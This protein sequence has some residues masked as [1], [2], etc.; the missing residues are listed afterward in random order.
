MMMMMP[1]NTGAVPVSGYSN[2]KPI[3]YQ[4]QPMLTYVIAPPVQ[5][6]PLNPQQL[7]MTSN[8]VFASPAVQITAEKPVTPI[9]L[10]PMKRSLEVESTIAP[11]HSTAAAAP[12]T[13]FSNPS[14][15]ANPIEP[16]TVKLTEESKTL[17][18]IHPSIDGTTKLSSSVVA[19]TE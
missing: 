15:A 16:E 14:P 7:M 8:P 19:T 10:K 3:F 17:I 18:D 5:H 4:Q 12:S 9:E 13:V 2:Q 6:Q 11:V 1:P